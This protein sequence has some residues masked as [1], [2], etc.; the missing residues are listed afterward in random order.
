LNLTTTT[1]NYDLDIDS[2]NYEHDTNYAA[3]EQENSWQRVKKR[4]RE[5][6]HEEP[7]T[8]TIAP[9]EVQTRYN[10][11]TTMTE[12]DIIETNGTNN[13][14]KTKT[15]SDIHLRSQKFEGNDK[16]PF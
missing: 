9:T 10:P 8:P 2:S 4:K 13:P 1:E 15:S 6:Q 16:K 12:S 5:T 7:N 11:L 3:K 14:P